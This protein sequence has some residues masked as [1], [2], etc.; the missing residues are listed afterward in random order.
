[1]TSEQPP[2]RDFSNEE[3]QEEG[4]WFSL[5]TKPV[6]DLSFE[7]QEFS[8]D[9]TARAVY[10]RYGHMIKWVPTHGWMVYDK[11]LGSWDARIGEAKVAKAIKHVMRER[12]VYGFVNAYE[13][14]STDAAKAMIATNKLA[15]HNVKAIMEMLKSYVA[16]LIDEFADTPYLLNVAN[17]V[18]DLRTGDLMDHDPKYHFQYTV[19]VK[20]KPDADSSYWEQWLAETAEGGEE[21]ADWLRWAMGYTLTGYTS[22][23][24]FFYVY[25]PPRSGKGVFLET[26]SLVMGDVLAKPIDFNVLTTRGTADTQGFALAPLMATRY[27]TASE[28]NRHERFDEAKL[29]RISGG[30]R[31]ACSFKGKDHFSYRPGFKIWMATN[32]PINADP[33]DAAAW[34]RLALIHFPNS[35]LGNEDGTLKERMRS[36]ENLEGVLAWMVRGAIDWHMLRESG[37]QLRELHHMAV[38]KGE[39]RRGLDTVQQWIEECTEP[40]DQW[41]PAHHLYSSYKDFC[42]TMDTDG[43]SH[44]G[45]GESLQAKGYE[46]KISAGVKYRGISIRT[47]SRMP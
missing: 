6:I 35:H 23:E 40:A 34:G 38:K 5:P 26:T 11:K 22:E 8:Q 41:L 10:D 31:I 25:G 32:F 42:K 14:K 2:T 21:T 43:T 39:Q 13:G 24:K 37:G 27:V 29:K 44:R 30:D 45:F 17:G 18:L 9:G 28:S 1:M 12:A 47:N 46:R 3:P 4:H 19:P 16:T 20:Y 15:N 7:P 36:T 33:D